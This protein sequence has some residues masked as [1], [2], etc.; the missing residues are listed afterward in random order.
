MKD[1]LPIIAFATSEDWDVWLVDHHEASSGI[2]LKIAK[3]DSGIDSVTYAEALE[4]ALAYGWIDGQKGKF[5]DAHWLQRFTPRGPRSRWSMINRDK[6]L[7]LIERDAMKPA[8]LREVERAR[9][10]GRW[11]AAYESPRAATV[12]DD[13]QA[14]LDANDAASEFFATLSGANRYAILYRIADAK[15]PETRARRIERYVEMLT[16]QKTL[17][18]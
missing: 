10:D 16:E 9:E 4:V 17:H 11:E 1:D 15:R 2:W 13:F 12:P 6:A 5:D 18:P 7:R 3:K 14:A 8:G